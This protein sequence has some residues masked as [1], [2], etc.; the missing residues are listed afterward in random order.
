[1]SAG[2]DEPMP[3]LDLPPLASLAG[4]DAALVP[5]R[6]SGKPINRRPDDE[7]FAGIDER[8]PETAR[9][10]EY[11]R[12]LSAEKGHARR[13]ITE[14]AK[15]RAGRVAIPPREWV[16]PDTGEWK[17]E[18][19]TITEYGITK[20]LPNGMTPDDVPE[21]CTMSAPICDNDVD[22][23][24]REVREQTGH[25]MT[26]AQRAILRRIITSCDPET[27]EIGMTYAALAES[28]GA[29]TR[30]VER[31][32]KKF[33]D[34]DILTGGGKGTGGGR[35]ADSLRVVDLAR[36]RRLSL[37]QRIRIGHETMV[38]RAAMRERDLSKI[39]DRMRVTRPDGTVVERERVED[40]DVTRES[41]TE[42]TE[43]ASWGDVG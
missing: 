13:G 10:M 3:F 14:R 39:T 31:A 37:E 41:L 22:D 25:N 42:T 1:M 2:W 7:R 26:M 43:S 9:I 40:R 30:T 6:P 29:T 11:Q 33:R 19:W 20:E 32:I 34:L 35:S 4:T 36:V 12:S 17:S 5:A 27:A 24:I 23:M 38:R 8:D 28:T 21:R 18:P 15:V 16:D